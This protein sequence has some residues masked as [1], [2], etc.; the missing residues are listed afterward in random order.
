MHVD[1][2]IDARDLLCP[3]PVLRLRKRLQTLHQGALVQITTTDPAAIIDIPHFCAEAGHDVISMSE[4]G[5]ETHW[6]LRKSAN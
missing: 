1:L 4:E 2:Y 5:R 6:I 3:L